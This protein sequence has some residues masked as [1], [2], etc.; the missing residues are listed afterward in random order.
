MRG[1]I[2]T[3]R[4]VSN[5]RPLLGFSKE[6]RSNYGR[7]KSAAWF[8]SWKPLI[9][10][11]EPHFLKIKT[12]LLVTNKILQQ[13]KHGI[14]DKDILYRFLRFGSFNF[15]T[16]QLEVDRP[17]Q[18]S[19]PKKVLNRSERFSDGA[20]YQEAQANL[21]NINWRDI[22]VTPWKKKVRYWLDNPHG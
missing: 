11:S 22:Q 9:L 1:C 16:D 8:I 12:C 6:K 15:R 19:R 21:S 14:D 10:N 18:P 4:C 7:R 3:L 17:I 5:Q 13:Q 20:S 2:L